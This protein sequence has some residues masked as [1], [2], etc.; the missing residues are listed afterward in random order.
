ML[1]CNQNCIAPSLSFDPASEN[2]TETPGE[3]YSIKI[4]AEGGEENIK[5]IVIAK[6]INGT[7]DPNLISVSGNGAK[8]KIYTLT[9][10]LRSNQGLGEVIIYTITA[11]ADCKHGSAYTRKSFNIIAG[12]SNV[13]LSLI[14]NSQAPRVYNRFTSSFINNPA[15][16]LQN[17]KSKF[18]A[19]ANSEKDIVDSV[20]SA[21]GNPFA[22]NARWGSRNGSLFVKAFGFD[23]TNASAKSIIDAYNAGIPGSLVSL[24]LNDIIIVKIRNQ[25]KFAVIRIKNISDDGAA[26]NED[27]VFWEYKLTQ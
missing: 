13:K 22:S 21:T 6:T 4:I 1:S 9:D 11:V 2:I 7:L 24:A 26:S 14:G 12:P 20:N 15:W 17:I 10:S 25:N 5:S 3:V 8:K 19:D 18:A 23:F 27:F 16:D